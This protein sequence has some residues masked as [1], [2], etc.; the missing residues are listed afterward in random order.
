MIVLVLLVHGLLAV[1]LLGAITH[2]A[3]SVAPGAGSAGPRSFVRRFRT[4]NPAAYANAIVVLFVI[5]A[6]GGATWAVTEGGISQ[7]MG[8]PIRRGPLWRP[9]SPQSP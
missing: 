9:S 7:A 8:G 3:L 5:T 2:Q 6:I 1:T 4:V